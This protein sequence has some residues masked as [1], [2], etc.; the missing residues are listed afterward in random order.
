MCIPKLLHRRNLNN[1]SSA[2]SSKHSNQSSLASNFDALDITQSD[3]KSPLDLTKNKRF[4]NRSVNPKHI[5]AR[6]RLSMNFSQQNVNISPPKSE[7]DQ[8]FDL[9]EARLKELWSDTESSTDNAKALIIQTTSTFLA[10]T[11][12]NN[13]S[14]DLVSSFIDE[15]ELQ[16]LWNKTD[17]SHKLSI[18]IYDSNV[19][20]K[21]LG[22]PIPHITG[23][24]DIL[25]A[26]LIKKRKLKEVVDPEYLQVCKSPRTKHNLKQAS[27]HSSND[28]QSC[29]KN[30]K[31]LAK[32]PA[33]EFKEREFVVTRS[34]RKVFKRDPSDYLGNSSLKKQFQTQCSK[35]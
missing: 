25:D 2:G 22:L 19:V 1:N 14:P 12:Q 33:N 24:S 26:E 34:G 18:P 5:H 27:S 17:N 7:L 3:Q 13:L 6:R 23:D 32:P 8:R 4:T 35:T 30:G 11:D 15:E 10:Q 21:T 29:K 16:E 9:V 28:S 20:A 31:K